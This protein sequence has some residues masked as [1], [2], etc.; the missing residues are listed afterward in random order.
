[1]YELLLT[2]LIKHTN[3]NVLF[4]YVIAVYLHSLLFTFF[5]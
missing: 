5:Q 3:E 4:Q 1:M 2:S